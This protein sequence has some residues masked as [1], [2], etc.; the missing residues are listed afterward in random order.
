MSA[1]TGENDS[2][3]LFQ[4]LRE[5]EALVAEIDSSIEEMGMFRR[6]VISY[7]VEQELL[8]KSLREVFDLLRRLTQYVRPV[9]LD[10]MPDAV[11]GQSGILSRR[12]IRDERPDGLELSGRRSRPGRLGHKGADVLEDM[13]CE[14]LLD[15]AQSVFRPENLCLSIQRGPRPH[16][17]KPQALI[18][19]IERNVVVRGW[20]ILG[21]R[22]LL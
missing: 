6:L 19:G 20:Q 8:E 1:I 16:P 5:E 15:A 12:R 18:E 11:H 17:Q 10:T 2:S 13:T 3:L 14:D 4:T 21:E 9:R 22:P 7:D